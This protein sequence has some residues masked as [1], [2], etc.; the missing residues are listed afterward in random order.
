[1]RQP[2]AAWSVAQ[3]PEDA[4]DGNAGEPAE[5]GRRAHPPGSSRAKDPDGIEREDHQAHAGDE[6]A[7][8]AASRQ[9]GPVRQPGVR[10][11]S[12]RCVVGPAGTG[13]G[14]L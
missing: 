5:A 7:G 3:P 4:D 10:A 6:F 2:V 12:G 9:P 13:L 8:G 11:V 14:A 1:M